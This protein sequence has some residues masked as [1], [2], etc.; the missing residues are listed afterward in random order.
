V[1]DLDG[2]VA[3]V[4]GAGRGLGRAEAVELASRGAR[5]V[6]NDVDAAPAAAVVDEIRAEGG[7]AVA[8]H[9]DVADWS[10]ARSLVRRGVDEW[11]SLDIVVNNAG[12]LRDRTIFNMGEDEFDDVVRVHLKGHFCVLRHA[13]ELWREQAKSSADGRVDGRVVNT[14]SEAGLSGAIGQPNYSAAKA[15]IIQLTLNV[16]QVMA[17]YGVTANAI[18]PRA[19]TRMTEAMPLFAPPADDAAFDDFAPSNVT[20]L[21]AFLASPA[22]ADVSGQVFV[23]WGRHVDVVAAPSLDHR[24]ES[25]SGGAWTVDDVASVLV[26]FYAERTPVADGFM[27]RLG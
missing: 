5:V 13:T 27:L 15:G 9:G 24:F 21:V 1:A 16:A 20:P 10:Y 19:R 25:P 26:P 12:F 18:C 7:D 2:K 23:V 14:A 3:V 6:V 11:G 8:D 17:K 4:T 22:A